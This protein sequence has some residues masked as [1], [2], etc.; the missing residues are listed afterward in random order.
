M[1]VYQPSIIMRSGEDKKGKPFFCMT[2]PGYMCELLDCVNSEVWVVGIDYGRYVHAQV[3]V[4]DGFSPA[5]RVLHLHDSAQNGNGESVPAASMHHLLVMPYRYECDPKM[6]FRVRLRMANRRYALFAT[7]WLLGDVFGLKLIHSFGTDSLDNFGHLDVLV[8]DSSPTGD[9]ASAVAVKLEGAFNAFIRHLASPPAGCSP[10]D[11][12]D[13]KSLLHYFKQVLPSFAEIENTEGRLRDAAARWRA[14]CEEAKSDLSKE[15]IMLPHY[16]PP[17]GVIDIPASRWDE[18]YHESQSTSSGDLLRAALL[19]LHV[20]VESAF[21][22]KDRLFLPENFQDLVK[23]TIKSKKPDGIRMPEGYSRNRTRSFD[24]W[25]CIAAEDLKEHMEFLPADGADWRYAIAGLNDSPLSL[26]IHLKPKSDHLLNV[27]VEMDAGEETKAG[28]MAGLCGALSQIGFDFRVMNH[29]QVSRRN[30][31]AS[32]ISERVD[33][34]ADVHAT[35]YCLLGSKEIESH[36]ENHLSTL[37]GKP[38]KP[39]K[40]EVD[41]AR[42]LP[43]LAATECR[44]VCACSAKGGSA[45]AEKGKGKAPPEYIKANC[46][47]LRR[48]F[49]SSSAPW[50]DRVYT[51]GR[52]DPHHIVVMRG[53]NELF[54]CAVLCRPHSTL[55]DRWKVLHKR[56]RFDRMLC[57]PYGVRLACCIKKA[58]PE[59][60]VSRVRD[61]F[62]REFSVL[63]PKKEHGQEQRTF[64]LLPSRTSGDQVNVDAVA[65]KKL[66]EGE[67]GIIWMVEVGKDA[68]DAL[69]HDFV[70]WHKGVRGDKR[71]L[72]LKQLKLPSVGEAG[73]AEAYKLPF[74][75]TAPMRWV[76]INGTDDQGILMPLL[77]GGDLD[78]F[79]A[80][81]S[82]GPCMERIPMVLRAVAMHISS[83]ASQS[84]PVVHFDIKPGNVWLTRKGDV[85]LIDWGLIGDLVSNSESDKSKASTQGGGR[86]KVRQDRASAYCTT[87]FWLFGSPYHVP[88]EA[89]RH[90]E[91]G[92]ET[93]VYQWG[94]LACALLGDQGYSM[95]IQYHKKGYSGK[96][97]VCRPWSQAVDRDSTAPNKSEMR[98]EYFQMGGNSITPS[99]PTWLD[100]CAKEREFCKLIEMALTADAT[101][102][103]PNASDLGAAVDKALGAMGF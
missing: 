32:V 49:R 87:S 101:R 73:R 97:G 10:V 48:Q 38:Y 66:A 82:E 41:W 92:L 75:V 88:P 44:L 68:L 93:M 61:H 103:A 13:E 9:R 28:G 86:L 5:Q 50:V 100:S 2:V 27:H 54:H 59:P 19:G 95:C 42:S 84:K 78:S 90:E 80:V 34:L 20:R 26:E 40:L 72:V 14:K 36:I 21:G 81:D 12:G 55:R 33:F 4:V 25:L 46:R 56:D 62:V 18:I 79:F 77:D 99:V 37:P 16:Y 6:M 47:E 17:Y 57:S 52:R 91:L 60:T 31:T 63:L 69:G 83:L 53:N 7:S 65:L 102:R 22:P 43:P 15:H 74:G 1:R 94:A 51:A 89:S 98:N 67:N 23:G 85:Y 58:L 64:E 24:M 8:E 76:S 11:L 96:D 29:R 70:A 35:P 71:T 30:G 3:P 39:K 45:C